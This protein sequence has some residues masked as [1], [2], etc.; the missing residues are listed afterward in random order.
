MRRI[1]ISPLSINILIGITL[2]FLYF[3]VD[4]TVTPSG[5]GE[6]TVGEVIEQIPNEPA[7]YVVMV[8]L[9]VL[10]VWQRW[11]DSIKVGRD[12]QRRMRADHTRQLKN[13]EWGLVRDLRERALSLR[14]RADLIFGGGFLALLAGIY[15]VIFVLPEISGQDPGRIASGLFKTQF[16]N[17]LDCIVEKKCIV[18]LTSGSSIISALEKKVR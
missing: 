17:E 13:R 15:G 2:L 8:T 10:R 4:T 18:R 6:R 7:F 3:V 1:L 9:V 5:R 16:G 14:A 11:W 12:T